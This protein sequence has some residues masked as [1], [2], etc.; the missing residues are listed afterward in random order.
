MEI[1]CIKILSNLV[2]PDIL[3]IADSRWENAD[4]TKW[5]CHVIYVSFGCSLGEV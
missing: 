1:L 4:L 5:V 2:F 3:K